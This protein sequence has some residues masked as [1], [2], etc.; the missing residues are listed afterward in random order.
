MKLSMSAIKIADIIG[1]TLVIIV[2][3]MILNAANTIRKRAVGTNVW[4]FLYWFAI[5]EFAF[6]VAR[7]IGHIVQHILG[8]VNATT[9]W[10]FIAPYS[11]ATNTITFVIVF[12]VTLLMV[13][14]I[15]GF[16]EE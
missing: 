13:R 6:A 7:S 11:G 14:S 2:S 16:A 4:Y 5:A 3:F 15:R 12:V 9:T 10:K 8:S 1:P